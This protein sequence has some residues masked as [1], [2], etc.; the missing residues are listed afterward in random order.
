MR[1]QDAKAAKAVAEVA[2]ARAWYG[3]RSATRQE[4]TLE[5][6]LRAMKFE[7]FYPK[8]VFWRKLRTSSKPGE[9]PLFPG[10]LFIRVTTEDFH[11]VHEADGFHQFVRAL[12]ADGIQRPLAWP[13][14]VI[15]D[16]M[17]RSDLGD[18]DETRRERHRFL[19]AKGNRV[20]ITKGK[21]AGFVAAI[22]SASPKDRRVMVGLENMTELPVSLPYS[23]LKPIDGTGGLAE[24]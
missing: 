22:L 14:E 7:V 15:G 17:L 3:V 9:R 1:M 19:P 24:K 2:P 23:A 4:A 16:L 6:A 20:G 21:W 18:F 8:W 10:Y 12:D 11:R 5:T 13:E